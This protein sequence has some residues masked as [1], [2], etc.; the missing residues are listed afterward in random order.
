MSQ[1]ETAAYSLGKLLT[2][3]KFVQ[4]LDLIGKG[5]RCTLFTKVLTNFSIWFLDEPFLFIEFCSGLNDAFK[6]WIK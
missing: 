5:P 4:K 3:I 1:F 2:V 6:L